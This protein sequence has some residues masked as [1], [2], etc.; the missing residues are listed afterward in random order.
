MSYSKRK[1]SNTTHTEDRIFKKIAD[2]FTIM[3]TI[4][5]KVGDWVILTYELWYIVF[6]E[7]W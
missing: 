3:A 4:K 5:V 6:V 2:N 1:I 7:L